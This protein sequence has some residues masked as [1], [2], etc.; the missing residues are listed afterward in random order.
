MS[1]TLVP[2]CSP[3]PRAIFPLDA[4]PEWSR[5]L[6]RTLR[7][8]PFRVTV[9]AAF[10]DVLEGCADRKGGTWITRELAEG[11]KALHALGWAQS[12]EVWNRAT[13]AL[14]GGLYG[15]SIGGLFAGESMFHRETDASKI[16]FVSLVTRLRGAGFRIFDVQVMSPHLASL[17]CIEMP[18]NE[19]L[20]A[21]AQ[22]TR[23]ACLFPNEGTPTS[24]L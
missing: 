5:S 24:Q 3:D 9:N 6:R 21:A 23:E 12:V 4:S 13:G 15:V 2:W 11:Y 22:A 7:L 20:T 1:A 8:A 10:A 19:F 16:A 18:R 14:T 17:G